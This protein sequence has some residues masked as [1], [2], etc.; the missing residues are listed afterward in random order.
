M[1]SCLPEWISIAVRS[2]HLVN[3]APTVGVRYTWARGFAFHLAA[4]ITTSYIV[5]AVNIFCA[6]PLAVR[7][8]LLLFGSL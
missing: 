1:T 8:Y 7:K 4:A 2:P 5:E 3:A 6:V